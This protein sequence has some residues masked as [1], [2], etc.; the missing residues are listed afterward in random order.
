VCRGSSSKELAPDGRGIKHTA[1]K[2][3][4]LP[5]QV[6]DMV[7]ITRRERVRPII[8]KLAI[9]A[10]ATE[11]ADRVGVSVRVLDEILK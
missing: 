10:T 5:F 9:E 1:P 3:R 7:I 4:E 8:F 2:V 6:Q 11:S